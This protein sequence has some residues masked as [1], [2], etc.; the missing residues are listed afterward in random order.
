MNGSSAPRP[1]PPAVAVVAAVLKDPQGRVLISERP[2]GKSLAGSWEFPGGKL[3]AG[4]SPGQA[5]ARELRE[6]L[7]LEVEQAAPFLQ[8][9]HDYPE[10]RVSLDVWRVMRWAGQPRPHENQALAW[11][12]PDELARWPLLPADL[13]IVTAL[14]L[15]ALM[16]VTPDPA[17]PQADGVFLAALRQCLASGVEFVQFRAPQLAAARFRSLAEQVIALCRSAGA[18]VVLN[19]EPLLAVELNAD[20]VHLSAA[21]LRTH[22]ARPLPRE[23]LVGASCHDRAELEAAQRC[24]VDYVVLGAVRPTPSHPGSAVLGWEGFAGLAR[25]AAVPVYG[26]GDL[27][28][29][30]LEAVRR[31]GGYGVAAVRALWR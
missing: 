12:R 5:L 19:A 18:R 20:G 23:W 8:L 24:G 25:G 31:H 16:L 29:G 4:E 9:V 13:P 6:E 27:G 30:D 11:V 2:A 1:R 26:I 21:R 3:E 15:P 17:E 28:A 7:G 14:R 22:P 10:Q